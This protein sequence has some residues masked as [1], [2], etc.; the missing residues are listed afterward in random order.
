[1]KVDLALACDYAIIDQF[2]KLS[3]LGI[4]E[5]IWVQEFP[6]VHPRLHLVMRLK[7]RR[8]EIGDHEV[9]IRLV[10]EN[11]E[12]IISGDGTVTFSEP[13]AGVV[14]IEA[15]TVLLFDVPFERPGKYTFEIAIDD[16]VE[17]SVP[18]T[19][20]I[21]PKPSNSHPTDPV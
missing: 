9:N 6:V 15:G 2:G 3:V 11:G 14:E 1:M 19:V 8:T 5:H 18:I 20:D 16:S 21:A 4:F 12:E 7:G 17:A 13:P 10:D